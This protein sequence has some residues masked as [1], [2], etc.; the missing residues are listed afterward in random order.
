M[1][2]FFNNF[3]KYVYTVK[4]VFKKCPISH[5]VPEPRFQTVLCTYISRFLLLK[6]AIDLT[7]PPF[8]TPYI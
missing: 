5:F 4:S 1:N 6:V 7:E 3:G 8:C 2:K